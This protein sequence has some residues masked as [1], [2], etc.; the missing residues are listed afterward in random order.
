MVIPAFSHNEGSSYQRKIGTDKVKTS[1]LLRTYSKFAFPSESKPLDLFQCQF[2]Q[3]SLITD[4][5]PPN[6]Q[7][8]GTHATLS[9][10]SFVGSG[11]S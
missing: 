1:A 2:K 3:I 7:Y 5:L 9:V 6:L 10:V 4:D 8:F 11:L